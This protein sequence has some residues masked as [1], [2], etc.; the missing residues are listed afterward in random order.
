MLRAVNNNPAVF[1]KNSRPIVEFSVEN[2]KA[3]NA[4][5]KRLQ[6]SKEK[7][8]NFNK[9]NTDN[10]KDNDDQTFKRKKTKDV[11][12][13]DDKPEFMGSVNN[14]NV[15]SLPSHIGEKI[16]HNRPNKGPIS[17]K[18]LKRQEKEKKNPKKTARI[19]RKLEE[20]QSEEQQSEQLS[21]AKKPKKESKKKKKKNFGKEAV[22]DFREEKKFTEMVEKYK[23]KLNANYRPVAGR[24]KWFDK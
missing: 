2:R 8:P 10:K 20:Q 6:K 1:N 14:P 4:R 7:N 9:N 24:E 19:K 16:R 15:R 23:Q 3:L 18:D 11:L 22:K 13:E 21:E 5:D 17:R 12:P